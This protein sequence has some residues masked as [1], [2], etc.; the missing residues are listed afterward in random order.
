MIA[1]STGSAGSAGSDTRSAGL[2]G[3]IDSLYARFENFLNDISGAVIFAV[4][5]FVCAEVVARTALHRSILGFLDV[6]ELSMAAA[7]GDL[8]FDVR[9]ELPG[10][11]LCLYHQ[12]VAVHTMPPSVHP[13]ELRHRFRVQRT[14]ATDLQHSSFDHGVHGL[15]T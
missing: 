9:R 14:H 13:I 3:R 8:H 11:G 10:V 5:L 2:L 1:P 4:M 12:D 7:A 15:R 6:T